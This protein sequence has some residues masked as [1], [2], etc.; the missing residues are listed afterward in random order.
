VYELSPSQSGWTQTVLYNFQGL[1][2]GQYPV[3]GVVLDQTGNLYGTTFD[4]GINGG[5]I[6]YQLSPSG[7]AW[8]F[9][10]LYSFTGSFGGPYNKLTLDGKGN[11]YG[12]TNAEGANGL[13]SVF[14][15]T[16]D[17]GGWTFT[18]LYDFVGGVI[19]NVKVAESGA[20]KWGGRSPAILRP[21]L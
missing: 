18:D 10:T 13:G 19:I 1:D 11:I 4:G 14:K 8:T 7:G 17:N 15:L 9:T 6:V 16:P 2:D 12:F 20:V 21:A 5:G 3:G